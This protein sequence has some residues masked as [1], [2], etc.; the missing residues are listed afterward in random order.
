MQIFGATYMHKYVCCRIFLDVRVYKFYHKNFSNYKLKKYIPI[1]LFFFAELCKQGVNYYYL[2]LQAFIDLK[3]A[4][5]YSLCFNHEIEKYRKTFWIFKN[6][7]DK[8][9]TKEQK[10][11]DNYTKNKKTLCDYIMK[12]ITKQI[13][14]LDNLCRANISPSDLRSRYSNT[15]KTRNVEIMQGCGQQIRFP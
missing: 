8:P 1:Y 2:F 12:Y 4:Y 9:L 7:V 15:L 5:R 3:L 6:L 14:T 10:P 11:N 13:L